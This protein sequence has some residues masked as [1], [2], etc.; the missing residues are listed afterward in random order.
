MLFVRND[1]IEFEMKEK[2][3][4]VRYVQKTLLNVMNVV[5]SE[6]NWLKGWY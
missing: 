5:I 2:V 3:T 4:L 6:E 1:K